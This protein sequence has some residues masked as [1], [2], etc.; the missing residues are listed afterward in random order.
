MITSM[1]PKRAM[2][3]ISAFEL[4][5]DEEASIVLRDVRGLSYQ[6]ISAICHASQETIKKRRYKAFSKI[7]DAIEYEKSRG[8]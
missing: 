2:D 5:T 8:N 7:A 1:S 3:Y 6:Q 4:P